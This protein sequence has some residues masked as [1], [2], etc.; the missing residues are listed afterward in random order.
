MTSLFASGIEDDRSTI[1]NRGYTL[2][3]NYVFVRAYTIRSKEQGIMDEN[4]ENKL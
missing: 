4:T 3:N 2:E 1:I